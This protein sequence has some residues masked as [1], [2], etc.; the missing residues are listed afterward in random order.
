MADLGLLTWEKVIVRSVT[1]ELAHALTENASECERSLQC[2]LSEEDVE[3]LKDLA[4][5]AQEA[6]TRQQ[7]Q[8]IIN[9]L[10]ERGYFS[11]ELA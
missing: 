3:W 4:D 8:Q 6:L 9:E 2:V 5:N 11:V 1:P 10:A 7:A